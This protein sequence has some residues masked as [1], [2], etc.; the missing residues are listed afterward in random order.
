MSL[1]TGSPE[2]S[3]PVRGSRSAG[4]ATP[5]YPHIARCRACQEYLRHAPT[6]LPPATVISAVLTY[7]DTCHRLDPLDGSSAQFSWI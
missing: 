4:P 7:H 5:D 3:S 2:G 6:D 1:V